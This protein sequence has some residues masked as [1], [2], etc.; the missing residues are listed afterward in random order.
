[1]N[2]VG[3]I[4]SSRK[5]VMLDEAAQKQNDSAIVG[6]CYFLSN[7]SSELDW[8][9]LNKARLELPGFAASWSW[10]ADCVGGWNSSKLC[11]ARRVQQA[12]QH[13][14]HVF[15]EPIVQNIGQQPADPVPIGDSL[16]YQLERE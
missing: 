9:G 12:H 8:N 7:P 1:M 11:T 5:P 6:Y 14:L 10:L 4:T 3:Q 2:P 13:D 15:N 16:K